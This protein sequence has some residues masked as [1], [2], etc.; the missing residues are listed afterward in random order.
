MEYLITYLIYIAV[1]ARAI[2]WNYETAA[3]PTII[4]ILL[5]VFGI[6]LFSQQTLTRRFP[7]Y[8]RLYTLI[9]SAL[10]ITLLY[11][12]PTLDFLGMLLLPLCFQAVQFFGAPA[13]FI[14]I[15]GLILALSGMLFLGLEWEAGL[16]TI[17]TGAGTGFLMGSFAYLMNR[18]EGKRQENQRMFADLQEAYRLLKDSATQAEALAAAVER[19]RLVR[20]LHDSLTQ[21]LFSMNLAA[22]SAQLAIDDSS[23]L[24]EE[25][26]IRLQALARN[27]S[28]EV[29]ALTGHAPA[30]TLAQG[31]LAASLQRLAEQRM[32]QDGMNVSLEI[33]G[34]R[35]LPAPVED[36]LFRITQEALNNISRHAGVR[37]A[38][39]C[40]CLDQPVGSLEIIDHGC[41]FDRSGVST[42]GFGLAGMAD[43]AREIGWDLQIESQP[44]QGTRIRVEERTP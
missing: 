42:T 15:T 34:E 43:R 4:W 11:S 30:R 25:Q 31:G 20:E 37:Q 22:Q 36:N 27:A 24:A 32:E 7:K 41:G 19:H 21:T 3:I 39:V 17:I 9:Q 13:G 10:A 23:K 35:A 5:A 14:W 26:L 8:T 12:A 18:T 29:Q 40:L 6:I 44:G 16:T 28:S 2:G 1:I 33:V 38:A